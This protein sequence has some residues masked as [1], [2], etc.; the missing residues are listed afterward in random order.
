MH[1]N[2][3]SAY[4]FGFVW[5][6]KGQTRKFFPQYT[7]KNLFFCASLEEAL[8]K[9]LTPHGEIYIWGKKPFREVEDWAKVS[10]ASLFRIEDGFIRSVSLGSDLTRAYSL[11]IDSRG[12]YFD[13]TSPS[14]LEHLLNTY[15]FDEALLQRAKKLHN[16][17]IE[18]KISKYNI[19]QDKTLTLPHHTP[20]QKVLL[21]IGQVEDDASIAYGA[22][23]LTN[24]KFLQTVRKKYPQAYLIYKPHPDVLAGNRIGNIPKEETLTYANT[25]ITNASLDSVLALCDEVHTMTSLVGFEA[26][27]RGKSVHT[28]GLPFYAGWGLTTDAH[29]IPRRRA[30]RTLEELIAA[31]YLL[32]PHYID[33]FTH[34][35]CTAEVTIANIELMKIRYNTHLFYRL[36]INARNWCSRKIQLLIKVVLGE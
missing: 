10:K 20:S 15:T 29:T 32:Y 22:K 30:K 26:L 31:T 1:H 5:W 13:P 11:V 21:V 2:N 16:Y 34:K 19:H 33:P 7:K 9:G 4:F 8:N 14:D 36:G 24:R 17:L 18:K 3:T 25:I 6:K 28:Y 27:L 12:I 23:G 35:P